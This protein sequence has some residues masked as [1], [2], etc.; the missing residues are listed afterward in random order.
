MTY[1]SGD[2][3]AY[4]IE[5]SKEHNVMWWSVQV[6]WSVRSNDGC[7]GVYKSSRVFDQTTESCVKLTYKLECIHGVE[8]DKNK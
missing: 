6:K 3:I 7:R 8:N 5:L 2:Y 4:Y 1:N